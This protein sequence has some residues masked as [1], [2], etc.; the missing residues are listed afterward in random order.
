MSAADQSE[1]AGLH[2]PTHDPPRRLREKPQPMPDDART[3]R[4]KTPETAGRKVSPV[5]P[6]LQSRLARQWLR[7]PLH[8][9]AM[10]DPRALVHALA[11]CGTLFGSAGR[12]AAAIGASAIIA[13]I[14]V[15]MMPT[16]QQP[17]AGQSFSAAMEPFKTALPQQR[18]G[19]EPSRPA[20]AGFQSFLTGS[21]TAQAA[22]HE[23]TDTPQSDR[24]L[25]QFLHWRQRANP[26]EAAQ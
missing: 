4:N 7:W 13:L 22:K 25:Q 15:N 11:Q 5:P 24:L 9:N 21:G 17:D 18:Q 20:L 16:K 2:D 12:L 19:D 14:L 10:G 8:L 26:N 3:L 23:R 1:M 6:P